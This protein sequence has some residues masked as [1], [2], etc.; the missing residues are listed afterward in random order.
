MSL[1]DAKRVADLKEQISQGSKKLEQVHNEI[2]LGITKEV[3]AEFDSYMKS[4]DFTVSDS[5]GGKKAVYKDLIIELKPEAEAYFGCYHAFSLR[6]SGKEIFV[7]VLAKFAGD[8]DRTSFVSK[9]ELEKL[10]RELTIIEKAL[11]GPKME[12][13]TFSAAIKP[14]SPGNQSPQF[15]KSESISKVIDHF[16]A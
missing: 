16:T 8:Q 4:N 1:A 13:Y 12:S 5:G 11:E 6:V 15:F 9:S 14:K 3:L 7:R 10:E 2:R